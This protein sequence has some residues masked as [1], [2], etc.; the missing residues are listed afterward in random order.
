MKELRV[1]QCSVGQY[2]LLSTDKTLE[3]S[4]G[5]FEDGK[6]I[7][8]GDNKA[9]IRYSGDANELEDFKY[10]SEND[11][12]WVF[13]KCF[14]YA[15]RVWST[16]DYLGNCLLFTKTYK[17][18]YEEIAN[19]AEKLEREKI[20]KEIDR[21]T[22][23]LERDLK[24]QDFTEDISA[25]IEKLNSTYEKW[26]S[27]AKV[28]MSQYKKGSD[29]YKKSADKIKKYKDKIKGLKTYINI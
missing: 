8:N 26:A 21:L 16:E 15:R 2:N 14:G 17:E 28:E 12:G 9:L 18:N 6:I 4:M 11:L 22:E 7:E 29:G 5:I 24:P 3:F 19:V 20:Q 10:Y 23:K 27:E 13:E 1:R 25:H